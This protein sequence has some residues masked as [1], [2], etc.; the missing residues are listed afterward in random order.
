MTEENY[1]IDLKKFIHI[2]EATDTEPSSVLVNIE[3]YKTQKNLDPIIKHAVQEVTK[4]LLSS[5]SKGMDYFNVVTIF[6]QNFQKKN[7]DIKLIVNLAKIMIQL[8][9]KKLLKY[10]VVNPPKIFNIIWGTL[11]MVMDKELRQKVVLVKPDN[12]TITDLDNKGDDI[13]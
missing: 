13:L 3:L 4:G 12:T 9:P 6:P 2:K 1:E 7:M 8:F 5:Q 10:Y 11:K